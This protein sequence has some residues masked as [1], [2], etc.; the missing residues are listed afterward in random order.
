[1]NTSLRFILVLLGLANLPAL[2]LEQ[3]Q[4][5]SQEQAMPRTQASNLNCQPPARRQRPM[6]A[7]TCSIN[8]AGSCSS[9]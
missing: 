4:G 7:R 9:P 5:P 3:S 6:P 2:A 1:M 8:T